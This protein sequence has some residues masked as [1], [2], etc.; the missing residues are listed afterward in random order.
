MTWVPIPLLSTSCDSNTSSSVYG[1]FVHIKQFS[2]AGLLPNNSIWLSLYKIHNQRGPK[3]RR[4]TPWC[5]E[6]CVPSGRRR[7]NC[8]LVFPASTRA[9]VPW[10]VV[11][12][13]SNL[14]P[15]T[16]LPYTDLLP[17]SYKDPVPTRIIQDHR[18]TQAPQLNHIC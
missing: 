5:Q 17:S 18:P 11:L 4:L 14:F 3:F 12:H 9:H 2:S 1:V 10:L 15:L 8:F 7:R 13:H 16:H 6:G